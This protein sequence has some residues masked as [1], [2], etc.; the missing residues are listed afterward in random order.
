VNPTSVPAEL[1]AT[2]FLNIEPIFQELLDREILS[3]AD[4]ER[5]L[6][7]R[8]EL[9]A[10]CS[11]SGANL[12]ITMTC[13]T[14][15]AEAAAAY[16]DFIENVLPKI[17]PLDFALDQRQVELASRF[18]LDP[19][20]YAVLGNFLWSSDDSIVGLTRPLTSALCATPHAPHRIGSARRFLVRG[21]VRLSAC[22]PLAITARGT[23]GVRH[24]RW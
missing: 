17:K 3:S 14:N 8:S 13:D 15:D 21:C 18:D 12:Y 11:E 9:A 23:G 16:R 6:L 24:H 5:W 4:L 19:A 7:D 22:A 20:R 10:A 1:D 2:D